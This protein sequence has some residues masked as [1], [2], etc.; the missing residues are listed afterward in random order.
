M[1]ET[2][3]TIIKAAL[4]LFLQKGY[5]DVTMKELLQATN[6]SKGAFYHHF[7]SKEQLFK[8]IVSLFYNLKTIDYNAL[9][10]DNL[11]D[12]YI[13]YATAVTE[14]YHRLFAYIGSD[15]QG[16]SSYNFFLIWF[17]ARRLFPEFK[18]VEQQQ[19]EQDRKAWKYVIRRAKRKREIRTKISEEQIAQLFLFITE[20]V[21]LR[22][23]SDNSV[24]DY[25][26]VLMD[27]YDSLYAGLR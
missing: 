9:S 24:R 1:N 19:F 15:I 27:A 23:V 4:K 7:K 16:A 14:T 26:F 3:K 2:K 12:F 6:L 13:Q 10:A 11:K 5:K 20:G 17:D 22:F 21:F 25:D 18:E 8:V